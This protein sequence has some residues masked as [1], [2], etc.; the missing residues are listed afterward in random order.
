[1]TTSP[2]FLIDPVIHQWKQHYALKVLTTFRD[3]EVRSVTLV[4][5]RGNQF[6]LWID[7]PAD[8]AVGVHAWDYKQMRRD[9]NIPIPQLRSALDQALALVNSWLHGS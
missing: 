4:D 6:Q 2:Y 7:P 9:W 1:M 5:A 8:G 3:T